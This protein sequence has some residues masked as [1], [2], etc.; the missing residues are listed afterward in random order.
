MKP[1]HALAL[2]LGFVLLTLAGTGWLG[3]RV[4]EQGRQPAPLAPSAPP[5]GSIS[6]QSLPPEQGQAA[7]DAIMALVLPDLDGRRQSIAQWR[8]KVLVVNYWASWCAPC[9]EEMPA[10][11]RLQQ[12]YAARGVQFVGI[13]IDEPERLQA[14]ARKTP[15]GYPLLV[16][17]AAGT[18]TAAL[19]VRGLPYTVVIDH[20]GRFAMSRLGRL[21]EQT[22]EPVLDRLTAN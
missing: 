10:F 4:F 13:G 7:T 21:D 20:H 17:E 11:S 14:F 3:Y 2:A 19:Q 16:G 8:G 12:R 18:Q 9:L 15:V 5:A 6:T 22:L 1:G